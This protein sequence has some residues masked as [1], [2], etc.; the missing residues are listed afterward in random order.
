MGNFLA[1]TKSVLMANAAA[2]DRTVLKRSRR[3]WLFYAITRC[4]P[5]KRTSD[6]VVFDKTT[7]NPAV[8]RDST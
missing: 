1:M 2:L 3:L 7:F 5:L 8:Q 6:L 4:V